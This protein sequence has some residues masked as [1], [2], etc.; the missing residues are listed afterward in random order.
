MHP[1]DYDTHGN[2]EQSSI[3]KKFKKLSEKLPENSAFDFKEDEISI[4]D[5]VPYIN[6]LLNSTSSTSYEFGLFGI[7]TL[8]YDPNLHYY[9]NDLVIYPKNFK[10]YLTLLRSTLDNKNYDRK[11]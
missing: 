6:L 9:S 1:R 5:Y 10:N 8:I 11:K 4:Y 3:I 7:R 2:L